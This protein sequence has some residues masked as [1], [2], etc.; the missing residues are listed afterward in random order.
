[1][2]K[3]KGRRQNDGRPVGPVRYLEMAIAAGQAAQE[4]GM[5]PPNCYPHVRIVHDPWCDLLHGR[6]WCNCNPKLFDVQMVALPDVN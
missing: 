3:R 2:A 5:V 1:M 6:L 4:A